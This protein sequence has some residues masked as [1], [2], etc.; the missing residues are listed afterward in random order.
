MEMRLN[1]KMS[2]SKM[3]STRLF[4]NSPFSFG[5]SK[6]LELIRYFILYL[7]LAELLLETCILST[8]K[9]KI[10]KKVN[11]MIVINELITLRKNLF[12]VLNP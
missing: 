11:I 6:V 12:H 3:A 2:S 8:Y 9:I 10:K 1:G 5:Y 4:T 7:M